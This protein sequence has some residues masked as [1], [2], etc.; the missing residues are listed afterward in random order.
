MISRKKPISFLKKYYKN[1]PIL[2]NNPAYTNFLLKCGNKLFQRLP[3]SPQN[4]TLIAYIEKDSSYTK[5]RDAFNLLRQ[6]K[7]KD[8]VILKAFY[9]AYYSN[10][11]KK[12]K[13]LKH[14]KKISQQGSSVEIKR[15]ANEIHNQLTRLRQ[16]HKPPDFRLPDQDS[17]LVS[18]DSLK[19]QYIYLSFFPG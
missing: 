7:L 12:E 4:D 2:L 6:P 10:N 9:D 17:N 13:I 5:I 18:L 16:G 14:I 3:D 11:F 8:F 19:E 15:M 1:K